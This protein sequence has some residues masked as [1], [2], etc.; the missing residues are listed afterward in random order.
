MQRLVV[1]GSGSFS[2]RESSDMVVIVPVD[3]DSTS[4]NSMSIIIDLQ[5]PVVSLFKRKANKKQYLMTV[6]NVMRVKM[7]H[8]ITYDDESFSLF[9]FE[10]LML[11][12]LYAFLRYYRYSQD[13][14]L[15][16]E[17]IEH[18]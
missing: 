13:V 18:I 8:K 4:L 11:H 14:V 10:C 9:C 3:T 1:D 6:H 16:D 15:E 7:R 5:K 2:S 17:T 12:M